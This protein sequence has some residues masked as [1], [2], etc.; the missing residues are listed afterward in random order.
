MTRRERRSR[1]GVGAGRPGR[2][3]DTGPLRRSRPAGRHQ[4]GPDAGQRRRSRGRNGLAGDARPRPSGRQRPR[5]G[6]RRGNHFD[7]AAVDHRSDRRHQEL[8]ARGAGVGQ[9]DRP[10]ATT[11]SLRSESSARRHCIGVGGRPPA[12]APS[13]PSAT[14]P[15][16]RLSV[17]SVAQLDSAS[18]SFSSLSGWAQL[19]LRDRFLDLTDEVWRV[20]AF[21]DFLSYCF[22]AEGAVDIAAEPEVSVWDLAPLDI[23]VREAGGTFTG[24]DG[25]R[26]PARRQRG[27]DQRPAA[28]T[29][30]GPAGR[31]IARRVN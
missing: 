4:T 26:R 31:C 6:V 15:A 14:P 8:R 30:P 29:G 17:S 24:L 7:R 28:R 13:S 22:V 3:G 2:R 21:G 18:L 19:G 16:R 11:A 5:R 1:G 20:R 10:A 9:P 27:G 23:L 12:R 25:S